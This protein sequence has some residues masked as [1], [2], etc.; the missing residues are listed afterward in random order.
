LFETNARVVGKEYLNILP[1]RNQ[2][3]VYWKENLEE[4]M[5]PDE[6]GYEI[7]DSIN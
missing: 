3:G 4:V 7:E 6:L 5:S 1:E 2:S